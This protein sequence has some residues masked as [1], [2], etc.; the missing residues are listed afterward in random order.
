MMILM[1]ILGASTAAIAAA[2]NAP[3]P[4][5]MWHSWGLFTS[6]DLSNEA[7][8]QMIALALIES[9]MAKAGY[10]TINVVCN[11]WAGRNATTGVLIENRT[12]WPSGMAGFSARL[13]AMDPPLKLGCYTAPVVKNCMCG[14]L[15]TGGCEEGSLG[16]EQVDMDFFAK[17]GCDHV[18]VDAAYKTNQ[19]D[20]KLYK[21]RFQAIGDAIAKSPNPEMMYG[22]W[23]AGDAKP[24]KWGADVGGTYWRTANDIYD[25]WASVIRQWDVTYSI[26]SIDRF[27]SPGHYSFLDQM[28]VGDVPR[29]KG[30]AY[31]PGLNPDETI[32]HM[33]MWVMAASPLMTCTDVRNMTDAVKAVLTNPEL[34][35]IHKDPLAKMAYRID[36]GAGANNALH[37]ANQCADDWPQCQEGPGD[38]NYPGHTCT[39]CVDEW[40]VWEKPLSDGSYAIMVFNRGEVPLS[41]VPINAQDIGDSMSMNYEVRDVWS[42]QDLPPFANWMHVAVPA[43]GVRLLRVRTQTTSCPTGFTV[44]QRGYWGNPT[45]AAATGG[46][47]VNKTSALCGMKCTKTAGC[48]GFELYESQACYIFLNELQKPFVEDSDCFTCEVLGVHNAASRN[49]NVR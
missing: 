31:G 41:A 5:M 30:S 26:P 16:H 25:G 40:S 43:H 15:P 39:T 10:D 24:W 42:H 49:P 20:T 33:S 21:S 11:G 4:P 6:E 44:H 2:V 12:L 45:P 35:E 46:D 1:M 18:M 37:A 47:T 7:N 27:T 32:A 22:V 17:I 28:I 3:Y 19:L 9:G 29:R 23:T 14:T 34:L 36:V 8:M 48:K 38:P 13:H